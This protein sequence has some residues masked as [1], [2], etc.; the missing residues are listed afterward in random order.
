MKS[1]IILIIS[2]LCLFS[3]ISDAQTQERAIAILDLSVKNN[4]SNNYRLF[5]VEHMARVTGIPYIITQEVDIAKN[6]S[7]IL[8][9]SL[10]TS[11]TFSANEKTTLINYVQDGGV[12]IAP[13]IQKE[14]FYPLFGIDG[15][16]NSNARFEIRWDSTL[17]DASLKYIDEAEERVISLG[18]NTYSSIFFYW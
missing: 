10:F 3:T 12:L 2:F 17:A 6:Y 8:S 7:M 14:D 11:T 9:S 18:R 16:E 15:Y 5:S 13:R 1:I 4:E